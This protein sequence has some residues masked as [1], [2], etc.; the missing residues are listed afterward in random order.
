MIEEKLHFCC[1]NYMEGF[2]GQI[3]IYLDHNYQSQTNKEK[4]GHT[5]PDLYKHIKMED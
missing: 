1:E 4:K 5:P 2:Y 3:G